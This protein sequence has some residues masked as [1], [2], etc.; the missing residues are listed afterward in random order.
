MHIFQIKQMKRLSKLNLLNDVL[1]VPRKLESSWMHRMTK[2]EI[3]VEMVVIQWGWIK[4]PEK[5]RVYIV[6]V[7]R[8]PRAT[9]H[10]IFLQASH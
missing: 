3:P 6:L 10:L 1:P 9:N 4:L 2:L 5:G 8:P 7:G